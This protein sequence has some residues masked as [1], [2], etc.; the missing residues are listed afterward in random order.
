MILRVKDE[1][2]GYNYR[3]HHKNAKNLNNGF[4]NRGRGL[5]IIKNAMDEVRFEAGGSTIIMTKKF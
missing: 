5:L 3:A 1:G 4:N 2:P